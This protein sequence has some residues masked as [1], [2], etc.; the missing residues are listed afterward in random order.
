M[1]KEYVRKGVVEIAAG[2]IG[3]AKQTVGQGRGAVGE[4]EAA[5][6]DGDK[7]SSKRIVEFC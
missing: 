1:R 6:I 5:P 7:S 4:V 2:I 3:V